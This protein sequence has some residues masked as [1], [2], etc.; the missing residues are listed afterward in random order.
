MKHLFDIGLSPKLIGVNNRNLMTLK[1]DLNTSKEIIPKIREEFSENVQIVSESGINTIDDIKFLQ[2]SGA[3][4][5]LIGSSIMQ[6]NN[7]KQKILELRGV[8]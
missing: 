8:H 4:A 7:I 1:I 2:S 6:S 5:F 3:D